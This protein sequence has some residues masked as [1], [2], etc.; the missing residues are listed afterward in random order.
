MVICNRSK[1]VLIRYKRSSS[2]NEGRY[3]SGME[4]MTRP[5]YFVPLLLR[6]PSVRSGGYRRKSPVPTL[7]EVRRKRWRSVPLSP[8]KTT[9]SIGSS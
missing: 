8:T 6:T 1:E 3:D 7:P 9:D 2:L 5:P 4:S